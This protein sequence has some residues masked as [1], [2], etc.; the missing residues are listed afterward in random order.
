MSAWATPEKREGCVT[1]LGDLALTSLVLAPDDEDLVV[2]ANRD[3]PD[4]VL[5]AELLG[6]R[7]RHDLAL[8]A[9]RGGEV[10][11]AGLAAVR[12]EA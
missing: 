7:R 2:L 10:S 12:S 9:R 6:E 8:L 1:H 5:A 3:R 11:L 4:T